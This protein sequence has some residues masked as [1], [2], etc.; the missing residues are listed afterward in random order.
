MVLSSRPT[1]CKLCFKTSLDITL[2][3]KASFDQNGINNVFY[4]S[5][6]MYL[7]YMNNVCET[8]NRISHALILSFRWTM[9]TDILYK[10]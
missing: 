3:L 8:S 2:V 6:M 9:D 4:V 5:G 10:T 1:L 7:M